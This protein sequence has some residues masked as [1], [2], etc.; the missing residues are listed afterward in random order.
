MNNYSIF[1]LFDICDPKQWKTISMKDFKPSGYPVFGA[2]GIIGFYDEYNHDKE[3]L[4][5]TCRGATCGELNICQPFSYVN[6]N[7]MALDNLNEDIC[8]LKFLFF[9]LKWRGLEDII[10]GTAQPQITRI[11]LSKI[12]VSL[13]PIAEQKRIAAI[14]D[15]ADAVRR[16]RREA[17]RLTEELLRSAF[18]EMFGDP[19]TNPKGWEVVRLERLLKFLTTG[20]RGWAKYY[21][22]D[23]DLFLR[24]QNVKNCRLKM[25]DITYVDA[26]DSVEAKRI[27]VQPHDVLLSM[28]ADLGRTAVIPEGFP[29]A[30]VN[31]HLAILRLDCSRILS[32]YLAFFIESEGGRLQINSLNRQGVKAGLNFDDVKSLKILLPPLSLQ[33]KFN[34]FFVL[35]E[36]QTCHLKMAYSESENL[37]NSLLQRAFTDN[38]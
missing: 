33:K 32:T 13:P 4:L 20:S 30:Y 27:L 3:T 8:L 17:I 31:Q 23:G 11:S 24:I 36:R 37:F 25:D 5:I 35:S 26:P 34:D 22:D 2:N 15:K 18:L 16:K 19:V 14:L 6:G 28:T 12:Q 29:R 1:S 10:T 38:L 7:A 21:R 9:Y